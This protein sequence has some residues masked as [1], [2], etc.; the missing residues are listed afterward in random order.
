[1]SAYVGGELELFKE[2]HAW[3]AYFKTRLAPYVSGDVLEVGC[4]LGANTAVFADL[5]FLSWTCLEPDVKL[6]A[7]ARS[8]LAESPR[9][10]FVEGTLASLPADARFDAVLYLDV[11]EHIEDDAAEA[12]RAAALLKPGGTL[13]VLAPAHQALFSPF[14]AA[15]GHHRR[16]C[17]A[18]LNAAIPKELRPVG[19]WY[20]DSVGLLASAANRLLL[21]QAA[22]TPAQIRFWDGCLVPASRLLDPLTGYTLGKSLLGVWRKPPSH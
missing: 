3:K 2:A 12:A 15:I 19:L 13:C 4:G 9:F 21:R 6:L 16:Y 14:D 20:M 8:E 22:P 18:S 10:R 5:K 1:M 17:R 11:L 7:R